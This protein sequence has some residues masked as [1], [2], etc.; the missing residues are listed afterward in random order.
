M[1]IVWTILG[2]IAFFL[3]RD[4]LST[5][6]KQ[7][8]FI[9]LLFG[10]SGFACT[11]YYITDNGEIGI[12]VDAKYQKICF[13]QSG[14][15]KIVT[16][17]QIG[18]A[19]I[20]V[21]ENP[22]SAGPSKT[23]V[24]AGHAIGTALGGFWGG[25]IGGALSSKQ[26]HNHKV[27]KIDLKVKCTDSLSEYSY[28]VPFLSSPVE[29][30]DASYQ[31]S[32][33]EAK[34]WHAIL[35]SIL[36][37]NVDRVSAQ[38]VL[39]TSAIAIIRFKCDRCSKRFKVP[40][41]LRGKRGKCPKCGNTINIPRS[42]SPK[43]L[44]NPEKAGFC[45]YCHNPF[46]RRITTKKM[47][48][49]LC[50]V[51]DVLNAPESEDEVY[52]KYKA[53]AKRS[54]MFIS[55]SVILI[56]GFIIHGIVA[57][58]RKDAQKFEVQSR[59]GPGY[60]SLVKSGSYTDSDFAGSTHIAEVP[61]NI[62]KFTDS[63]TGYFT[64]EYPSV[65]QV[66]ELDD[67]ESRRVLFLGTEAEIRI[68]VI[69]AQGKEIS[70]SDIT[71]MLKGEN[72]K[73]FPKDKGTFISESTIRIAGLSAYQ[74]EYLQNLP[75]ARC[76]VVMLYANRRLHILMFAALND[77]FF[78]KWSDEFDRFL[79]SY[80]VPEYKEENSI[81]L[82]ENEVSIDEHKWKEYIDPKGR[83]ICQVPPG[84]RIHEKKEDLRSKVSFLCADGEIGIITR[85]TNRHIQD[86]SD[87]KEMVAIQQG[88][89]KKMRAMGQQ[90]RLIGV[91]WATVGATKALKVEFEAIRPERFW[92]K[93]MKFKRDKWDH[94]ITLTVRTSEKQK[95]LEKLFD[96]F[97]QEY[98]SPSHD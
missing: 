2:V 62:N 83:F 61:V 89:V 21:D 36:K 57:A 68:R 73:L 63:I 9:E 8:A 67:A 32:K 46:V 42:Q 85:N 52:P 75:K 92:A 17:R 74:M 19:E 30:G 59:T 28:I 14:F 31:R 25:V 60:S 26:S 66:K 55:L 40:E 23:K 5:R 81:S 35:Y 88:L 80:T 24:L 6:S 50:P 78:K 86:E 91:D 58:A 29:Y 44:P 77:S 48:T 49:K 11:K 90:A 87:R 18:S 34:E 54:W 47:N 22:V 64:C 13:W 51:C 70:S 82:Q 72:Q 65:W 39:G 56:I 27:N 79:T 3:V 37:Q 93:Q 41:S 33:K 96:Q 53:D 7:K 43:Q 38:A 76:R 1:W 12:G 20:M 10:G 4:H 16:Y 97:L 94:T 69:K 71:N 84:W 45:S 98:R 15:G 95:E